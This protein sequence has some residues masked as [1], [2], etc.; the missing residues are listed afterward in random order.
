MQLSDIKVGETYA[1]IGDYATLRRQEFCKLQ[2]DSAVPARVI[3]R[4]KRPVE[5]VDSCGR[6]STVNQTTLLV[7]LFK[8]ITS[9]DI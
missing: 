7:G 6:R 1:F 3:Q 2:K 9:Q 8:T 4:I 5:R